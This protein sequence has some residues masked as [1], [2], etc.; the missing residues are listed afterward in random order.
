MCPTKEIE[1]EIVEANEANN[2]VLTIISKCE[3]YVST[4][5]KL[6]TSGY[7]PNSTVS[8]PPES[9]RSSPPAF[10]S[11]GTISLKSVVKPKLPKL[12]IPKFNGKVT[13]F[14]DS[15]NSAIHMNAQLA[16]STNLTI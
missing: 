11:T 8:D 5:D 13:K 6:E 4:L 14:W 2:S 9:A 16:P 7:D 10:P 3:R 12:M 15:F 1:G